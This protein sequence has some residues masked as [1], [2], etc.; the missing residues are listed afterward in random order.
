MNREPYNPI[1][2]ALMEQ[3]YHSEE[4]CDIIIHINE[5]ICKGNDIE[6]IFDMYSISIDLLH[7]LHR[8]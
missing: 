1:I 6:E 7:H 2:D 3:G 5:E 4:I 8:I